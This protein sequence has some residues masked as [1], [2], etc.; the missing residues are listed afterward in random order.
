MQTRPRNAVRSLILILFA[1]AVLIVGCSSK[2]EESKALPE[3]ATL[4]QESSQTTRD[5]KSVHL[6]LT[7]TGEIKEL[8]IETLEGDLTNS[9]TVAA[10]GKANILFL[11]QRLEDV[12]FV[13]SDGTLYGALTP[14]SWQDLGPAG[15]IYDVSAILNPNTGLA[16]LLASFTDP[17]TEGRETINGVETV[18]ITGNVTADA[19]NKIAPQIG[20][21]GPV[22]GTAWIQEDDDHDLVQAKLEPTPGNSIQMTLA[23]WGKTVTVTKP[24]V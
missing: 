11:G 3:A 16:N 24:A 20:A 9:P 17:K 18:R 13:V 6:T 2:S 10:Q 4:L 23:D 7:V 22:P 14:N 19:V 5:L 1:A 21:T 8:P 15:D 12:A